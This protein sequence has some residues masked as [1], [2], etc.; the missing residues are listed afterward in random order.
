MAEQRSSQYRGPS[1]QVTLRSCSCATAGK[2]CADAPHWPLWRVLLLLQRDSGQVTVDEHG[3]L[4][5]RHANTRAKQQ[6]MGH[7]AAAV[8]ILVS[9]KLRLS[10]APLVDTTIQEKCCS[11]QLPHLCYQA[12][13]SS[14][15]KGLL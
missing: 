13:V 12:L 9:K 8:C 11:P 3:C 15:G 5:L 10:T 14:R 4:H 2:A 7:T 1:N 6:G